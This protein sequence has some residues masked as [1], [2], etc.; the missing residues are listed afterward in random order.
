MDYINN[1]ELTDL[2]PSTSLIFSTQIASFMRIRSV[3]FCRQ[4]NEHDNN[5]TELKKKHISNCKEKNTLE[6]TKTINMIKIKK[7]HIKIQ[8]LFRSLDITSLLQ[9]PVHVFYIS[10]QKL[11]CDHDFPTVPLCTLLSVDISELLYLLVFKG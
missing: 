10:K 8:M 6:V 5:I 7:I 9:C 11:T 1:W 2:V 3:M 4:E